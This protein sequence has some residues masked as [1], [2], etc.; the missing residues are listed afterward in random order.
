MLL[1]TSCAGC[2]EPGSLLCHRC[3]FSLSSSPPLSTHGGVLAAFTFEGV[4]RQVVLGLK[5]RNQRR[6][7]RLLA[8][9]M[10]QRYL[11]VG[12]GPVDVVTWAPTGARRAGERGFDQAE[13][14]A[15]SVA[16]QLGVPC[17]RML[18][19]SHG[20]AQTGRSRADRLQGPGYRGRAPRSGLRVLL[21][22]DVVTTGATLDA[23]RRALLEAGVGEVLSLVAAATPGVGQRSRPA[24]LR[25]VATAGSGSS[26]T[27]AASM[28][29]E[30]AA[31]TLVGTSSRNAERL[32]SAPSLSRA[33]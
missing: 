20:Q 22:D 33:S 18:Y 4:G 26:S 21:I 14:L 13:L 32:A 6:V 7:A 3:R 25:T 8:G 1:S 11:A 19:R 10:V 16:R 12:P 31:A 5:Y 24:Q 28:P 30:C 9:I 27:T 15:R 2:N 23:A 29:T 17:R